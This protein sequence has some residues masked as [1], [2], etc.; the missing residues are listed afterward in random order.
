MISFSVQKLFFHAPL[1]MKI[2]V[3]LDNPQDATSVQGLALKKQLHRVMNQNSKKILIPVDFSETSAK[4]LN[5][6]AAFAQKNG[7]S[8][9][10]LHVTGLH[11]SVLQPDE[12]IITT[13]EIEEIENEQ[14]VK[15]RIDAEHRFPG[16]QFET[17]SMTGFPIE[18]IRN[19]AE[20]ER[21][22][23]VL[24]GTKGAKG[25]QEFILGSHTSSLINQTDCA[26][27]AVPEEA[28]FNGIRRIVIATNLEKED[29]LMIRQ[30]IGL[31]GKEN[32]EI[33][34]LHVENSGERD[35][36]A[37]LMNWFHTEI[38]PKIQYPRLKPVCLEEGD[39]INALEHYLDKET[40][41]LLVTST[42]KR[43]FFERIFE[44][45]VTQ[46]MA[47]HTRIPLLALHVH[48]SKGR[49]IF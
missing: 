44:R 16:V 29:H 42:R 12:Q 38:L 23:L 2:M 6:G 20:Q 24:M 4:A 10:L 36:E 15:W 27:L 39:V 47:F 9:I 11:M 17:R 5:Y 7:A 1:L 30:T 28:V 25:A 32:P 18:W 19:C 40:P 43:N 33:V 46:K 22:D 21:V 41:D 14:L 3:R 31:F 34:L 26:V 45:S 13:E 8:L 49:V 35:P 37:A 48:E